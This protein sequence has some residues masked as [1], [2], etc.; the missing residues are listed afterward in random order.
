[1]KTYKL[2]VEGKVQGVWYRKY[3]LK[4]AKEL[5]LCGYVQNLSDGSVEVV[6]N[7]DEQSTL[8]K[9][10]EKL[11]KGSPFSRVDEVAC[12]QIDEQTFGEFKLR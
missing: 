3:T 2:R 7:I 1:M 12:K 10:I 5:D 8:E 9:F 11:Y 6:A 4:H